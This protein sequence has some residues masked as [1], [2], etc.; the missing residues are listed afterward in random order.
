MKLNKTT[1]F[2]SCA[3]AF[4]GTCMGKGDKTAVVNCG[5]E[6]VGCI[7]TVNAMGDP[8]MID[9]SKLTITD[10]STITA[11]KKLDVT[12]PTQVGSS[13]AYSFTPSTGES[14]NSKTLVVFENEKQ[15]PGTRLS[16]KALIRIS[17]HFVPVEE[18]TSWIEVG[19]IE[20]DGKEVEQKTVPVTFKSDSSAVW[21][22]PKNNEPMVFPLAKKDL[23][24]KK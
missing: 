13:T 16:G 14:K 2:L 21:V 4:F 15:A 20:V 6:S 3:A 18:G 23:G 17:R 1:L 10:L 19:R 5:A 7:A 8:V 9:I 22:D 11:D 12:L 24:Q